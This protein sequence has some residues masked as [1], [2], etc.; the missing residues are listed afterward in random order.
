MSQV[1]IFYS[2]FS[3]VPKLLVWADSSLAN[4]PIKTDTGG[5]CI[6]FLAD[7]EGHCGPL[8]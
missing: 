4:L 6:V 7:S 2:R 1:R 8:A 3:S 5:G